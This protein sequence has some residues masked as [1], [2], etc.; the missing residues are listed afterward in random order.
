MLNKKLIFSLVALV[1]F[2]LFFTLNG[3]KNTDRIQYQYMSNA[4]TSGEIKNI[5]NWEV[6]DGS[7]PGCGNEGNLVC[8]YEFDGDINAF[9]TFL[10]SLSTTPQSLLDGA[11]ATKQ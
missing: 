8:R 7:I 1:G 5:D 3:F 9:E 2:G 4:T 10:N 6:V 11:T